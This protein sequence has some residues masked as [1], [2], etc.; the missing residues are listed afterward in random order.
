MK[1]IGLYDLKTR[2]SDIFRDV[3][4]GASYLVTRRGKVIARLV[5]ESASAGRAQDAIDAVLA[6]NPVPLPEGMSIKD[7]I[8]HGRR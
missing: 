5:P 3:E 7:L 8:S 1:E 2:A 4:A 6:S